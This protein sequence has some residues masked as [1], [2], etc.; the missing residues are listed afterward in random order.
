MPLRVAVVDDEPMGRSRLVR[1]MKEQGCEVVAELEN[2]PDFLAWLGLER[3]SLDGVFLDVEMP[4]VNGLELMAELPAMLPV[5]FVTAH[6]GHAVQAFES[7]AVDYLMKPVRATRLEIALARLTRRKG[8]PLIQDR[9][10]GAPPAPERTQPGTR[11]PVRAGK[12]Q[13]L[14]EFRKVTRFEVKGEIV[15]A[16]VEGECY[17]TYWTALTQLEPKLTGLGFIRIQRSMLLRMSTVIGM[18]SLPSG[19]CMARL[20]DGV[21]VEVSRQQTPSFKRALGVC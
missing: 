13:L 4:G 7:E 19:R 5:V 2:G 10:K 18:R 11:F 16:W 8:E 14:I 20:S 1:L 17:R 6:P 12:G 15:W 3:D 9:K 21:E